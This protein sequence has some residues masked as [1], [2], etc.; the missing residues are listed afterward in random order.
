MI[1]QNIKLNKVKKY[2]QLS[3]EGEK[4]LLI[5]AA[6]LRACSPSANNKSH[7][8]NPDPKLFND[9]KIDQIKKIGNYAIKIEFSDGHSTGIYSWEYLYKVGIK[10]Q[11]FLTP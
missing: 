3:Y 11:N 9:I 1:P 10:F 7:R 2:I 4:H 6:F 5:S 8:K